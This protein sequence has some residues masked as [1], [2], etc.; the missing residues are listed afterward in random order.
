MKPGHLL[1]VL[2]CLAVCGCAHPQPQ[3]AAATGLA[4]PQLMRPV[5]LDDGDDCAIFARCPTQKVLPE[6]DLADAD[7]LLSAD[8]V[9]LAAARG[10]REQVQLVLRPSAELTGLDLSFSALEGPGFISAD[11]WSWD[12][13]AYTYLRRGSYHYGLR[14]NQRGMLPDPLEPSGAFDA[15]AEINTTLLLT[16]EVP[17]EAQPGGY[18]GSVTV[19]GDGF[20]ATVPIALNVWDIRMPDDHLLVNYATMVDRDPEVLRLL[21]EL[22]VNALKYGASGI[23][24]EVDGAGVMTLDFEDYDVQVELLLDELGYYS[25]GVPPTMPLTGRGPREDYLG[26]PVTVGS[27]EFWPL[28]EQYMGGLGDHMR[29]RGLAYR[30]VWKVG[31]ELPEAMYPLTAELCRRAKDVWPELR[32]MLTTNHMSD[33]LAEHLDIWCPGWH[34]FG[35]RADEAPE[36]WRER[37]AQGMELWAYLNSAYM[38]NAEWNPGALRIFPAALARNGFTGAL[39]WS[40]RATGSG[41]GDEWEGEP[42]PW[43]EMRPLKSVKPD[44][45]Y[46]DFGNGHMLYQPRE[47]DPHWRSSLRWESFRQGLDEYDLLMVLQERAEGAAER[48]GVRAEFDAE[49]MMQDWASM[50]A[51][52][53]RLQTYRAEA[54]WIHRFRQLIAHEIEALEGDPVALVS[55]TPVGALLSTPATIKPGAGSETEFDSPAEATISGYCGADA[56]VTVAGEAVEMTADGGRARFSHKVALEPGANLIAIEVTGADGARSV[57][58]R[59]LLHLPGAE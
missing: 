28:F 31:D 21:R 53:F 3:M 58:Y 17:R 56:T 20:S 37:R 38:I 52:G 9:E 55:V 4:E 59:E 40:L 2:L 57:F 50:L 5:L 47:H 48:L 6:E 10:E 51:T 54:A 8:H 32:V 35:V 16:I 14:T 27:D 41:Y 11:A 29:E 15:P 42:D 7:D 46:Y 30:F 39:W 49:A 18:A 13:V 44:K 43:K 34:L 25:I 33:E 19:E 1:V 23:G 36:Q 12:R 45:T 26:I 24:V 22:D